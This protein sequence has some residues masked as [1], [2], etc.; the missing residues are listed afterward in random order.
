MLVGLCAF[1]MPFHVHASLITEL[2]WNDALNGNVTSTGGDGGTNADIDINLASTLVSF[3]IGTAEYHSFVT[4]NST[5]ASGQSGV[6]PY[7]GQNATNLSAGDDILS[8]TDNRLD[9][10]MVNIGN[11]S[12]FSFPSS[13]TSL[14]H[15]LFIFDV[16]SADGSR[17]VELI[18]GLGGSVVGSAGCRRFLCRQ[19]R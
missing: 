2:T 9:T 15:V 10:G 19:R 12:D 3:K 17:A 1:A 6:T 16:G 13:P 11:N 14:D 18:D 5:N 7:W 4:A 8:V